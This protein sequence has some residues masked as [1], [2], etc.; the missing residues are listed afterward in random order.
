[1]YR[2]Y[3]F[4]IICSVSYVPAWLLVFVHEQKAPC[5]ICSRLKPTLSVRGKSES[6]PTSKLEKR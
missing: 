6:Q 2:M 1:M 3:M 5:S 4:N